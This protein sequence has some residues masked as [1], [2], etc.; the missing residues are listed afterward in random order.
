MTKSF[1]NL[2]IDSERLWGTIHETAR[3]G[4][5]PKGGVRRLTLGEEDKQARDWF[6]AACEAA[7][8]EVHVDALGTMFAL[9]PGRDMTKPPLGIG[10]HLD[11]QPTGGKYDGVLGTL[12]ALEVVRTLNA[13]GIETE[14]PLCVVNWTNEEGSRFAPAMMASG[15]YAGDFTTEDILARKDADGVT[16]AEALEAIGYRGSEA[17]GAR[18]LGAF[19]ELHI[20]QGPILE[21]EGKTIGVVHNGQGIIWYDGRLTGFASHAGTTPM[22]LRRDALATFAEVVLAVE[23][24]ARELGPEAVGTI[25]EATIENASRNV[26]PGDLTFT[27]DVRSANAAT[28]DKFD[29]MLRKVFEEIA[30]RRKVAVELNQVWRK[31]PT[32]FDAKLVD[33]VEAAAKELGYGYR[34]ITSGAGHDACN[35]ATVM[36]AAMIFV[37]C[38]DGVSH[39]ELEDATQADCAAG[40]NVLLHT[41][42]AL[43]GVANK[44]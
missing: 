14:I 28:L 6:R 35:L 16:V 18:R 5:T 42:L 37:P 8:C 12:A 29:I 33:A 36:P 20:E 34:R 41:V 15:T 23:R 32:Q 21:A 40:A 25:G 7:G 38:K 4:A 3:F 24:I 30:A 11:T 19:I 9:R 26:V 31:E 27:L 13:A 43:A 2:Q 22:P 1:S 44:R 39:N 10:S 17:V